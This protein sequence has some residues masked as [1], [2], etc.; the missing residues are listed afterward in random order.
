[1][2]ALGRIVATKAHTVT[3]VRGKAGT[4]DTAFLL[5]ISQL[6]LLRSVSYQRREKL[7]IYKTAAEAVHGIPDG[8]KI[9]I[10]G[11]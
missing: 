1:M 8:A 3:A 6:A 11:A 9:L 2:A 5:I 7:K 10:G 4:A